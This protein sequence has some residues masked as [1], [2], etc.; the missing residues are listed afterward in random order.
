VTSAASGKDVPLEAETWRCA[1]LD[2]HLPDMN[3]I[4][5]AARL[6]PATPVLLVSGDPAAGIAL[7]EVRGRRAWYLPK[8]FEVDTYLDLV[9]LLVGAT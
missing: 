8:P 9:S 6:A 7:A 4:E 5:I 3:G 1:V 2:Y